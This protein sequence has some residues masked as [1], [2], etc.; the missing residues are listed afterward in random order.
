MYFW[1]CS[2]PIVMRNP[3]NCGA[4]ISPRN[5][6]HRRRQPLRQP[7]RVLPVWDFGRKFPQSQQRNGFLLLVKFNIIWL[8][9]HLFAYS[10]NQ[11]NMNI[12]TIYRLLLK[13]NKYEYLCNFSSV[14]E[15]KQWVS[16]TYWYV[17]TPFLRKVTIF[18]SSKCST[19][20]ESYNAKKM[21]IFFLTCEHF[22]K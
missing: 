5:K 20:S 18:F 4:R 9:L 19:I 21:E 17:P 7:V 3:G 14:L 1:S 8:S 12:F 22:R 16:P 2:S 6:I 10:G 13:P 11:T 15:N